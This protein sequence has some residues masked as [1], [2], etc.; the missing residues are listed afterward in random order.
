MS[1]YYADKLSSR[2]LQRCYEIAPPRVKQY[3]EAELSY[4]LEKIKPGQHVL[5][6]G[7]GYGRTLGRMAERAALVVGIDNAMSSLN[8]AAETLKSIPNCSLAGMDA[9][10]LALADRSFDIVVCIQNGL[11]AFHRNQKSLMAEAIRV[12]RQGGTAMFSTYSETFWNDR[13]HWFELQAQAGLLGEID[14]DKTGD[15]EIVC[16][17]GFTATTIG[18][19]Q[20]LSLAKSL[21]LE[22][23]LVEIDDSSL[24]CEIVRK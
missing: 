1:D 12:T 15:G 5:D 4:V 6:L 22:A 9:C 2:R 11:S 16:K 3:L 8:Q 7:C 10:S 23:T 24:F 17:D 19:D 14:Y 13:L 20:F 18:P 21:G